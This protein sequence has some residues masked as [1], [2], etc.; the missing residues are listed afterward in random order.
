MAAGQRALLNVPTPAALQGAVSAA[1]LDWL[2]RLY[3]YLGSQVAAGGGT[4][5]NVINNFGIPGAPGAPGAPGTIGPVEPEMVLYGGP[6]GLIA[7]D[8]PFR[9]LQDPNTLYVP[10]VFH[11]GGD[12]SPGQEPIWLNPDNTLLAVLEGGAFENDRMWLY[13]TS[14]G[15]PSVEAPPIAMRGQIMEMVPEPLGLYNG[16]GGNVPYGSA[17]GLAHQ[18]INFTYIDGD[19]SLG[20]S[21]FGLY[22][23]SLHCATGTASQSPIYLWR[24][25]ETPAKNGSSASRDR[26]GF[27]SDGLLLYYRDINGVEHVLGTGG[28]GGGMV[29]GTGTA[30]QVAFWD[31]TTSITG[32][33]N[34]YW[35]NVNIK[36]G[37]GINTPL[38][39][40]DL[41]GVGSGGDSKP[42][43][44]RMGSAVTDSST[45]SG[46]FVLYES[47]TNLWHIAKRSS[48]WSAGRA[49]ALDITYT[50]S[51]S[52]DWMTVLPTGLVGINRTVPSG[53]RLHVVHNTA[54]DASAVFEAGSSM[55]PC[56]EIKDASAHRWRIGTG[57]NST[58][59]GDFFIYDVGSAAGRLYISTSGHVQ[60]LSTTNTQDLGGSSAQWRDFYLGRTLYVGNDAG[61]SSKVL[62]GG[63]NPAWS[64]VAGLGGVTGTGATGRV[65]YWS[66]STAITGSGQFLWD[67]SAGLIVLSAPVTISEGSTVY[68]VDGGSVTKAVLATSSV[69]ITLGT[70][71][72]G[73]DKQIILATEAASATMSTNGLWG[74]PA[75][76]A[77]PVSSVFGGDSYYDT[78]SERFIGYEEGD[79]V[80]LGRV[81]TTNVG[82]T[83]TVTTN[84]DDLLVDTSAD[85]TIT[86]E[87]AT[88]SGRVVT[89]HDAHGD[90]FN[91]NI[92]ILSD[93]TDTIIGA[94]SFVLNNDWE[95]ITFITDGAGTWFPIA[96]YIP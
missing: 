5:I 79:W 11:D 10:H 76:A 60:P 87:P 33:A 25:G 52:H 93:G 34:L 50:D 41:I 85:R 56:I 95:S 46:G 3:D 27:Y 84:D 19:S 67:N 75:L 42:Q 20:S 80:R 94:G 18:D 89:I 13:W 49:N 24:G 2:N 53:A 92:T 21:S 81:A 39:G 57:W 71:V 22:V 86:L 6:D 68:S 72:H 15:E 51:V 36:L 64:T 83:Y 44:I 29:S 90:C 9:Y 59:A 8:A 54:A 74:F 26:G 66:S 77:A 65:A 1:E 61:T 58:T 96:H 70:G 45:N 30:T 23:P 12:G 63:T 62:I 4:V 17:S 7:Q 48:G 28:G 43:E 73:K 14:A 16:F 78:N 35:D 88:R 38:F 55:S 47:G 32:N 37:V 82:G 31:S 91:H 40:I 69:T